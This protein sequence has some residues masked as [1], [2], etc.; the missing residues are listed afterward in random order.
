MKESWE[1]TSK[2]IHI[3][4]EI[5]SIMISQVFRGK[6]LIK[7]ERTETGL[8]SGTYKIQIEGSAT[9]YLLRISAGGLDVASKE[10]A[11]A[12]RLSASCL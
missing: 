10:K 5:I 2:N 6:R 8:S 9:S 4:H 11:I 1:R 12:E 3:N 7:A